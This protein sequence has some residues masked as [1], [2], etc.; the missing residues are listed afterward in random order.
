MDVH[1]P[2]I[3]FLSNCWLKVV[4]EPISQN[5]RACKLRNHLEPT[6]TWADACK[7]FSH[8]YFQYFRDFRDD[9]LIIK[10]CHDS[11]TQPA[12]DTESLS[13]SES[14]ESS[15][16]TPSYTPQEFQAIFLDFYQFLATLHYNSDFW[17]FPRQK[18]GHLRQSSAQNWENP[19]SWLRFSGIYPTSIRNASHIYTTNPGC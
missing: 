15:Y 14:N 17:R 16:D 9:S 11:E 8:R 13:D 7:S 4:V 1:A 2:F 6:S 5:K 19:T 3:F 18:D 10:T 12:A